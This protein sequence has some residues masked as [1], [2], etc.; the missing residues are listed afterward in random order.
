MVRAGALDGRERSTYRSL[1]VNVPHRQEHASGRRLVLV[2]GSAAIAGGIFVIWAFSHWGQST[3]TRSARTVEARGRAYELAMGITRCMAKGRIQLPESA[4]PVPATPPQSLHLGSAESDRAFAADAYACAGFH[5][6]GELHIQVEWIRLDEQ[7]GVARTR[8]D[9]NGDGQPD[10]EAS[11]AVHCVASD[12]DAAPSE[13]ARGESLAGAG[14]AET[15]R[16]DPVDERRFDGLVDTVQS[17]F[18]PPVKPKG[19]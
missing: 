7:H 5:P 12:G 2:G 10:F 18:V 16:A 4:A 15:C 13:R 3:F 6:R 14:A 17:G 1:A 19:Y 11:S 9:E 8:L